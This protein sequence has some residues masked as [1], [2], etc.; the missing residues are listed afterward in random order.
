MFSLRSATC[1]TALLVLL[2]AV[3]VDA[4]TISLGLTNTGEGSAS[5]VVGTVDPEWTINGNTAYVTYGSPTTYPFVD[6][7]WLDNDATSQFISPQPRYDDGEP[8]DQGTYSFTTTFGILPGFDVTTAQFEFRMLTDDSVGSIVLNGQTIP[9]NWASYNTWSGWTLI[10]Q[11]YFVT[12]LNTLTFTVANPNGWYG[13]AAALRVEF[14]DQ[15]V[16]A[17]VPEPASLTLLGLGLAGMAGRRWRRR[18]IA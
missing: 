1:L 12:G 17:A 18:H 7:A 8:F 13:D 16:S 15:E 14:R 10:D 2:S 5:P 6:G 9:V 11:N 4:S 3:P